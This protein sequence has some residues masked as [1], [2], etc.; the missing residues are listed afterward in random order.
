MWLSKHIKP[1][2]PTAD[3]DLGMTTIA[4]DSVGVVTR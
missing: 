4:G 3:A 1:T 2:P